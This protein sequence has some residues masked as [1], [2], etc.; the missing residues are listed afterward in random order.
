MRFFVKTSNY[1]NS[2]MLNMCDEDLLGKVI[3]NGKLQINISKSYYGQRLV[4]K[5]EAETL[6]QNCSVLN[7]VGTNT[8]QMSVHLKIGSQQGVKTI[9]GVPFLIVFK[10]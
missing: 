3:K 2:N 8:I 4:E 9:D 10:M 1:Q 6:L 7:L 5:E